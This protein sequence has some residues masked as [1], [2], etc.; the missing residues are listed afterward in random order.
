MVKH[1]AAAM[2]CPKLTFSH[3]EIDQDDFGRQ[4]MFILWNHLYSGFQALR[5]TSRLCGDVQRETR[6]DDDECVV[7]YA[8]KIGFPFDF[9]GGDLCVTYVERT[10]DERV[11]HTICWNDNNSSTGK[12]KG[13]LIATAAHTILLGLKTQSLPARVFGRVPWM[14]AEVKDLV[15]SHLSRLILNDARAVL[16][17]ILAKAG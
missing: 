6:N 5:I 12:H 16:Q 11:T 2:L 4:I 8:L 9:R 10:R 13:R 14:P 3:H 17:G 7:M 15:L 1:I